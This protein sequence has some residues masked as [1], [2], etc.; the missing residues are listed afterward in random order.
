VLHHLPEYLDTVRQSLQFL[1]PGGILFINHEHLSFETMTT[2]ARWLQS[3]DIRLYGVAYKWRSERADFLQAI[4]RKLGLAA[5][6]KRSDDIR[7]A[8]YHVFEGGVQEQQII[9]E[10][11]QA[12][13]EILHFL[14]YQQ[15]RLGS[16]NALATA[17]RWHG[18]F[19]LIARKTG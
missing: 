11:K 4:G 7:L 9:D 2:A 14:P 1:K 13:L 6:A 5:P 3:L 17:L 8:D 19:C 18:L 16:L 12:G 15:L 10:L